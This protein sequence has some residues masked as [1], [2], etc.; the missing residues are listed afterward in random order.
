MKYTLEICAGSY[1]DALE[2]CKGQ[3]DRIELNSA[4]H[5]GGLTPSLASLILTKT[6]T[7]LKVI[8]MV[9]PRG[10]GFC[11]GEAD[12]QTMYADAKL[13][14]ENGA[15]GIAFGFLNEDYTIDIPKTEHM[16][17]IIKQYNKEAVF[18]RAFDCTDDP[19]SSIETLIK[20]K[21]D[22]V[23]TSGQRN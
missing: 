7:D 11:Y 15:D 8:C 23:L 5:L 16:V 2:A 13:L 10:G 6:S 21:I 3:A 17:S 14:L 19:Y 20:L 1:Y 22:R 9:R 4:L 12:T 18:H